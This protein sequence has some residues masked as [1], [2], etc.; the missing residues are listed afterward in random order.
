MLHAGFLRRLNRSQTRCAI[1]ELKF[2]RF[3]RARMRHADELNKR[4]AG[5]HTISVGRGIERVAEDRLASSRQLFSLPVRTN[6]RTLW[7]SATNSCISG[8]PM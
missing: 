5:C 2:G 7:P 3:C 8:L 1:N 4:M 6:A